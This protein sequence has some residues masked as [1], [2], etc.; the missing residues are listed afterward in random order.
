VPVFEPVEER[1]IEATERQLGVAF[2]SHYRRWLL[3]SNGG[4]VEVDEAWWDL[5]PVADDSDARR[6]GPTWDHVCRQTGQ[7][8]A[9]GRFPDAAIA[10]ADD[11][12]GDRLVLMARAP[13]A[14]LELAVWRH[15]TG[16]VVWAAV[17]VEVVFAR[18]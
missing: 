5:H 12:S 4:E 14:A 18:D 10:I 13:G 17:A 11:G 8:R 7:A 2:P 9:Q 3:H 1:Y 15:V 16:E 6:I